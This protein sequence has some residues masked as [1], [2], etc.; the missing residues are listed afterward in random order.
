MFFHLLRETR[1]YVPLSLAV[2]A[3]LGAYFAS[4][5]LRDVFIVVAVLLGALLAWDVLVAAFGTILM[6]GLKLWVDRTR[7]RNRRSREA[8][9]PDVT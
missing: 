9:P 8:Q 4:G 2:G 1:V 3:V 5:I 6:W 7:A